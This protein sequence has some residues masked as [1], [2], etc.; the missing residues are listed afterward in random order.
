[1]Q[2][3]DMLK[4]QTKMQAELTQCEAKLKAQD[5]LIQQLLGL[6]GYSS[7]GTVCEIHTSSALLLVRQCFS[8]FYT[9]F[10][11]YRER[12]AALFFGVVSQPS[13][14]FILSAAKY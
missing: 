14:Y 4:T 13:C 7:S 9:F 6:L 10:F 2:L 5:Q 11:F 3:D 1:M 8:F 12:N